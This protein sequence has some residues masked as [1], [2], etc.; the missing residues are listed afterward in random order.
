[1]QIFLS[2]LLAGFIG[3]YLG[4]LI[5]RRLREP[6]QAVIEQAEAIMGRRF[7]TIPEPRVPELRRLAIAM[8]DTVARLKAMF[9]EEALRLSEVRREANFDPLTSL[10]NRP[11]FMARLEDALETEESASGTL[12]LVRIADLAGINQRLGR[13]A[14]DELLRRLAKTMATFVERHGDGLAARL[15]GADFALLLP[16]QPQALKSAEE[17]LDALGQEALPY[18]GGT[19]VAFIGVGHFSHGIEK[20][21]LLSQVDAALASAQATGTSTAHEAAVSD[22]T[23]IPRSAEQWARQLRQALDNRWVRLISFPVNDFHGQLI[24]WESPLRLRLE[25]DGE[26]LP[27]GRFLPMAERLR[28]T[29]A[30]DFAA[31]RLGVEELERHPEL[32]GLAINL[33]ASSIHEAEF[34]DDLKNLLKEH[35]A[36]AARLWLEIAEVGAFRHLEDFRQFVGAVNSTG[37]RIGLEHFGRQ[38]SQIG[39]LHDLGLDYLKVDASF[40]R[41]LDN[42]PGNQ[43]FLRGLATLSHGIGLMVIGEGIMNEA[44]LDTLQTLGFDGITGPAV[45]PPA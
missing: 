24:H 4:S 20:G 14:T 21:S 26:W 37:C 38:F 13:A 19:P 11:F 27:A 7:V 33:S 45:T 16:P 5:L 17:L 40:I 34:R 41:D 32:P 15:N 29:P 30:L 6:L 1:M 31:A 42:S 28:L 8:N 25:Q 10:A 35:P 2:L 18:L 12:M 3:G 23:E 22:D 39:H 44:E 36:A 9:D 43:S